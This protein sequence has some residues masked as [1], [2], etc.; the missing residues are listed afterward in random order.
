[1][2]MMDKLYDALK[3]IRQEC[4]KHNGCSDCPLRTRD[5]KCSVSVS[6]PY[7]WE[8]RDDKEDIPRLIK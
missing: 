5:H 7:N 1:M 4:N 3:T 8:L 2:C 6:C